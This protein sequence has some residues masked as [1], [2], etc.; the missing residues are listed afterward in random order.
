[1]TLYALGINHQTAPV[2]LRERVA[3][4]DSAVPAALAEL[5]ALPGVREV[6]LLSTC[7]RTELYASA[8]DDGVLADWLASHPDADDA[9]DDPGQAL[10]AYLYRRAGDEAARHLFRVA[11]GLDSM[12]L[13]E[14]Q[15]LGQ[16]KQA[17]SMARD[18]GVLGGELDRL[19]QHAFV[20]AKRARTETRIGSSPVSVASLAVRLAQESFARPD[21]SVVLLIG[22]G[23][24]IELTARHLAQARVKRLLIANRTWRHAQEL[25]E[26]HGAVA[27]PLDE[28]ERH[29]F[30]ADVVFTA[31]A[32]QTPI[33]TRTQVAQALALRK[34]RPMLLMDL[35]VPRDI[36]PEV[37][38]LDDAFLYT[39]D[40]LDRVVE[41][42]RRS[43]GDAAQQAET[44]VDL[45]VGRYAQAL[46]LGARN[47]P[48]KR[49]RA[50]GDAAR[51]EL[52]ARARQQ[53]ATGQDPAT[54]VDQLAHALTNRL[55][56]VPTAAM[57]DAAA[58]GNLE[59]LRA[60]DPLLPPATQNDDAADPA[61]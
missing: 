17:W 54:V 2:A 12:V 8:D 34:R 56:H 19:F 14:P 53:L 59:L 1:M 26:R 58:R 13:G 29:L 61:P 5:R 37:A 28:L 24:T 60:F 6:A 55:L 57:R 7:N 43:R 10:H 3:F 25:A 21:D 4:A 32:S 15:I 11:C 22:A 49:L 45:Q 33:L 47:E 18:S 51:A 52:V 42:N 44:I 30:L 27:L 35:A 23:E 46:A 50:H 31:T 38:G 16:V 41:Q 36:E 48:L 20:T 39:V 40:D 9:G